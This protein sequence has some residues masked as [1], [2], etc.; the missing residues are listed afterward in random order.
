MPTAT[1][2]PEPTVTPMPEP[3]PTTIPTP[4]SA[5]PLEGPTWLLDYYLDAEGNVTPALSARPATLTLQDGEFAGNTGCNAYFGQYSLQNRQIAFELKGVSMRAC[6]EPQATQEAGILGALSQI[7]SYELTGNTLSLL[8]ARGNALLSLHLRDNVSLTGVHWRLLSLNNGKGGMVSD[9]ATSR[10]YITF[11]D[12]GN[13]TGNAG[14]N[15]YFGSWRMDDDDLSFGAIAATE[16]MCSEP[17]GVMDR[18]FTYLK[19]LS[20]VARYEIQGEKLTFFDKDD[21]KLAVFGAER[22]TP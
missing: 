1:L 13:I 16:M 9:A 10:I 17:A 5:S 20:K 14:C 18:E 3:V 12:D 4:Q 2:T 11:G 21:K 19:M 7:T 6:T 8:D 22:N 15:D